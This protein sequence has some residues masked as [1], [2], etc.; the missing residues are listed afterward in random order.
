MS[1]PGQVWM[2]MLLALLGREAVDHAVVEV[3]ELLEH[4]LVRP[5]VARV[6]LVREPALGEVDRDAHGAGGE[7]LPDVLLDLV[8]EVV[9]ELL[10][11][12]ALDLA[13]ERIQQ[14]QHRRGDHGLLDRLAG[15][16]LVLLDELGG[17]RLVA[18][19]AA[20]QARELAVVTVVEDGEELSVAGEVVGEAGAGQRVGD[21]V[22]GEA[23]LALL[24][25]GDTG[26][27]GLLEAP[28]RVL[29][30]LV[31]LGLQRGEVDLPVV[32]RLIGLLELHRA[33]QGSHELGG[34]GH[35]TSSWLGLTCLSRDRTP[36]TAAGARPRD[37]CFSA[38]RARGGPRRRA[39]RRRPC[40]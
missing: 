14:H 19:R 20:G 17:E 21:R 34:D 31:L 7:R 16:R 39:A 22:G 15:D 18:E 38:A 12:V 29:G 24:P 8:A 1:P 40:R 23:R 33:R 2:P 5:G 37:R 26:L 3:D 36:T 28:D 35:A 4:V 9:E 6:V 25:V 32:V 30:R 13:L 10:A 27:A 11:R